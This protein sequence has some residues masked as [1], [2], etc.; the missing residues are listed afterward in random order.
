MIAVGFLAVGGAFGPAHG[1]IGD[2][3]RG[4]VG[5][6]MDGV[7][8]ERDAAAENASE[9]FSDDQA[10]SENHSPAK[11][12]R[13]QCGMNVAGVTMR[14]TGM[15]V[16]VILAAIGALAVGMPNHDLILRAP[17]G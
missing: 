5:K 14:M 8:E 4:N 2:A 15:A 10:E 9:N 11:D 12:G 3:E 17:G 1:E 16:V 6:V 7:I 13:L